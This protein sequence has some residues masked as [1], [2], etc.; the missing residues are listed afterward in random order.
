MLRESWEKERKRE[1]QKQ[2]ASRLHDHKGRSRAGK[3][4][5]R[6]EGQKEDEEGWQRKRERDKAG[7]SRNTD[8]KM[9][10]EM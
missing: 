2:P 9:R 4:E 8:N 5:E 6:E 7:E 10:A 3:A 1:I